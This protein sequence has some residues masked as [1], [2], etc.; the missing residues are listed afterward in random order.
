[1]ISLWISISY[2][3]DP[4]HNHHGYIPFFVFHCGVDGRLVVN[5]WLVVRYRWRPLWGDPVIIGRKRWVVISTG[6]CMCTVPLDVFIKNPSDTYM[7][8]WVNFLSIT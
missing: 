5:L 6:I 8:W 4:D 1:M 2:D 7:W 3:Q